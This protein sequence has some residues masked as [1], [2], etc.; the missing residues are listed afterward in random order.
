MNKRALLVSQL[1]FN[2]PY[3]F[4]P[5]SKS[6]ISKMHYPKSKEVMRKVAFPINHSFPPSPSENPS[7]TYC[8]TISRRVQEAISNAAKATSAK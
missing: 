2:N 6:K 1:K 3:N 4:W 5:N 7:R 8:T